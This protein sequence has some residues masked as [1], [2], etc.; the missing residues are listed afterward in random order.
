LSIPADDQDAVFRLLAAC[1][2]GMIIGADR[3]LSG[4][5][6]GMRT[7]GLVCLGAALVTLV[8][9]RVPAIAGNPDAL[10][11]V[12]QGV[13]Q[14]VLT[15]IGFIGGGV[16]LYRRK[17][18]RIEGLT[19]ASAVWITAALGIACALASWTMVA[20]SIAVALVLLV[21][22]RPLDRLMEREGRRR[23]DAGPGLGR[24]EGS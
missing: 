20:V 23:V 9:I 6:T 2:V 12:L 8:T 17:A 11:R 16:V 10:S 4:K 21:G 1:A 22:V 14:G 3:G 5:P 18:G 7:L 13:I 24:D 19:T 15:G